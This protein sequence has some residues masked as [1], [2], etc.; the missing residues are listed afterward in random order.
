M[1]HKKVVVFFDFRWGYNTQSDTALEN[2]AEGVYTLNLVLKDDRSQTSET[3]ITVN[4]QSSILQPFGGSLHQVPGTIQIEDYDLGGDGF[5]YYDSTLGN[6]TSGYR[7]ENDVDLAVGG[8][9]IVLTDLTGGEYTRYSI[10]VAENGIY[11]MTI[12]YRTFSNASKPFAAYILP[13]N[14]SSSTLL[15][16]APSGS[17]TTGVRNTGGAYLDYVSPQFNLLAGNMVLE[18]RIPSGGAGP[19]YDY[20]TLNRINSLSIDDFEKADN[21][22]VYPVPSRDGRFN[23]SKSKSWKVYSLL[24]RKITEGD[25]NLVDISKYSKGI[26][27]LKTG[28]GVIKRLIYN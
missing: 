6:D 23:L 19:S 18:L 4:V 21:F 20:I 22:K 1:L 7:T 5:A 26:Y 24:G 17:T 9:G 28:N 11:E 15:F 14:L 8:S 25:G 2:M 13:I 27:I 12:N 3:S 10:N 16:S